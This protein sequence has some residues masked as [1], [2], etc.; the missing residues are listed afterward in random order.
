MRFL[1][2]FG[3]VGAFLLLSTMFAGA[4]CICLYK[5][6]EVAHG[7]TACLVTAGGR[8]LARCEKSL[9]MSTWKF[10]G[11]PCPT[12]QSDKPPLVEM[13]RPRQPA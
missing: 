11:E 1:A 5:G 12:A 6:G 3:V 2:K 13:S 8:E 7:Q 4:D 10:L 9:N